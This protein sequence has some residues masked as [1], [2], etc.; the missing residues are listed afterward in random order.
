MCVCVTRKHLHSSPAAFWQT[1]SATVKK[2]DEI[3]EQSKYLIKKQLIRFAFAFSIYSEATSS[4]SISI[5]IL[6][7]LQHF[8][9][10]FSASLYFTDHLLTIDFDSVPDGDI[11][12][13]KTFKFT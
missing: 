6:E 10:Q 13:Y 1:H 5:N 9:F 12:V 7:S 3:A 4:K 2:R 11:Y 8:S